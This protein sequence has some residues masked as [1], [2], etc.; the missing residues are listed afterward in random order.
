V[1]ILDRSNLNAAVVARAQA[2]RER[3]TSVGIPQAV[4]VTDGPGGTQ[5]NLS[6]ERD[7]F[8]PL[9]TI[10]VTAD[11]AG[12]NYRVELLDDD[13]ID[14]P[15]VGEWDLNDHAVAAALA[16]LAW[17]GP[18]VVE[19][20][21]HY[22]DLP[23]AS[24]AELAVAIATDPSEADP[25]AP[26]DANGEGEAGVTVYS[27]S[28]C[29]ACTAT[30]RQL[31]KAQVTYTEVDVRADQEALDRLKALGYLEL[32]VVVDG[33]QHWSGYRPDKVAALVAKHAP[34]APPEASQPIV[35]PQ[36]PGL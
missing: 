34:P 3:L 10:A 31:D 36:G 9:V 28:G 13:V 18:D 23:E 19:S 20:S 14:A 27:S 33:D 21:R 2:L 32:P 26:L 5:V 16:R 6:V 29:V 1:S 22:Y 25:W 30:K 24:I 7:P 8:Q 15:P 12:I 4:E 17:S 11:D 35:T